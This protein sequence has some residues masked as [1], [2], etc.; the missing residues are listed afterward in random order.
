MNNNYKI[1][2]VKN[3]NRG[4][5]SLLKN[6]NSNAEKKYGK[7]VIYIFLLILMIFIILS[8]MFL[9]RYISEDCYEKKPLFDYL[10][11]WNKDPCLRKQPPM[12]YAPNILED[13]KE[14][15][16]IANQDY[17]YEEAKCK[18]AAYGGRLAT[19]Q[20]IIEAYNRGADWCTYGWTEGQTAYYPTQK[21]TWDKLQEGD[22]KHRLDCGMP[23]INGGFFSNP[24][25]KFGINC[26]GIRPKGEIVREKAP[27]CK[28]RDFCEM[29]V[30]TFAANRLDT[31]EI[32]PFNDNQWSQ[33]G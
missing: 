10:F 33:F 20:E 27:V 22:P 12:T 6:M 1:P 31:D 14:V 7:F 9:L 19:K 28:G 25:L 3:I 4:N 24:K 21:C 30:N 15:F 5:K 8:I 18:C 2:Y 17:T 26:Y 13:R 29:K 16:H 23:G 32:A 11:S